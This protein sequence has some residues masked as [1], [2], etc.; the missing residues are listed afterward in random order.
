M[1]Q[2]NYVVTRRGCRCMDTVKFGK[3]RLPE[4]NVDFWTFL[5]TAHPKV[6]VQS[7]KPNHGDGIAQCFKVILHGTIRNKDF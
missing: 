5:V 2:E 3:K 7:K 4:S 1:M 6:T